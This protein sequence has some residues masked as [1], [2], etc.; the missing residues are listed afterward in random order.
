VFIKPIILRGGDDGMTITSMKYNAI[1]STQSNFREDLATIGDQHVETKL[2]P[3]N[4]QR[5]LPSPFAAK[6][7]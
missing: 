4:N 2:P 7:K 6:S 3:W 1:R 5:D